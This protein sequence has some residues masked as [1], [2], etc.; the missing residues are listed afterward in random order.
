MKSVGTAATPRINAYGF[1]SDTTYIELVSTGGST[2]VG[3]TPASTLRGRI[4][5]RFG[6]YV[7]PFVVGAAA[8]TSPM[9]A[10]TRRFFSAGDLSGSHIGGPLW[11]VDDWVYTEEAGTVEQI[12]ALNA[13]LALP[14][15]EGFRLDLPE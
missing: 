2:D 10:L 6:A 13:L 7:L 8:A 15:I 11:L 14:A 1:D 4:R 9:P 3:E 12:H 5:G